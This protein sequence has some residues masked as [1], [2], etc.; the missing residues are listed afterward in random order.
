M[1]D[2][3]LLATNVPIRKATVAPVASLSTERRQFVENTRIVRAA[4]SP[5][6]FS[7][8]EPKVVVHYY[9]TTAR[10]RHNWGS[11]EEEPSPRRVK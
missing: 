11:N 5:Q 10:G 1:V 3:S 2:Q 6:K 9:L 4:I 8:D 7:L